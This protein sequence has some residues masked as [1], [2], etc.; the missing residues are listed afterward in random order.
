MRLA[1]AIRAELAL[2][3]ESSD[4]E[5]QAQANFERI[6]SAMKSLLATL[7]EAKHQV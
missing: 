2:T 6:D 7:E 3:T 1:S 5:A 4:Y